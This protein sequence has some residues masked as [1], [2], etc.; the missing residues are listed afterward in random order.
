MTTIAGDKP[1][2]V[3]SARADTS[4]GDQPDDSYSIS[5]REFLYYIWGASIVM[6]LG[7]SAA[8][9]V[10]FLLPRF[11]AGE[12][13]G[14]FF[15]PGSQL[16]PLGSAPADNPQGRFWFSNTEAGVAALYKVCTHLGCL[17]KWV[18]T[19]GRFECPCHGSKFRADGIYIEGPAP[20]SLDRF[21]LSAVLQDGSEVAADEYGMLHLE[22]PSQVV[23]YVVRTGQKIQGPPA[24]REYT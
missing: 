6:L 21:E 12:F 4:P 18:G 3:H 23:Q 7:A 24:G 22:E 11:R 14:D 8:T 20:R 17:F 19:N 9:I 1:P 16:P 13:G 5:R 10:W 15:I 2:A